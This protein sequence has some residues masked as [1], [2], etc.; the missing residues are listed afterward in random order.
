MRDFERI[1][2]YNKINIQALGRLS[3]LSSVRMTSI[4]YD[5]RTHPDRHE[6]IA[7]KKS[8]QTLRIEAVQILSLFSQNRVTE[9]ALTKLKDFLSRGEIKQNCL[10]ESKK[11]GKDVND[12]MLGKRTYIPATDE[13]I[14]WALQTF[15]TET[16]ML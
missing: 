2:N 8:I 7:I 6:L 3:G 15:V 13:E 4:I 16:T 9:I 5:N 12:W 1:K 11:T 10:F 14:L